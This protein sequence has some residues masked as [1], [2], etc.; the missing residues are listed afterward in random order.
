M[1]TTGQVKKPFWEIPVPEDEKPVQMDIWKQPDSLPAQP[2]EQVS[3]SYED[4]CRVVEL[5]LARLEKDGY[6]YWRCRELNNDVILIVTDDRKNAAPAGKAVYTLDEL[7]KTAVLDKHTLRLVHA[8][9]KQGAVIVSIEE[10]K[11][12]E[13]GFENRG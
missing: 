2:A 7:K 1:S 10:N 6:C 5:T 11:N 8:A 3:M 12:Q 9:K 4:G 13:V